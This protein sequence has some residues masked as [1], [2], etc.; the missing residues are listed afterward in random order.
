MDPGKRLKNALLTRWWI[1]VPFV[2]ALCVFVFIVWVTLKSMAYPHDG[3]GNISQSGVITRIEPAGPTYSK[4]ENEDKIISVDGIPWEEV[5]APYKDKHSGD[6]VDFLI[7]RSGKTILVPAALVDPPLSEILVRL[8]PILV[9]LVFWGLG[10][11]VQ[12]FK[13]KDGAANL[14]FAWCMVCAMTLAAGV[15]S[16]LEAIWTS[17][18]FSSLLWIIGP[19]SVHFHMDFPQVNS[20]RSKGFILTVLYSLAFL[21]ILSYSIM[22]FSNHH[23]DQWIPLL[24]SIG[25]IYLG[26]NLLFV[27]GLLMYQYTHAASP[28]VRAKI[29]LVALG[30]GLSGLSI[31]VFTI[32]PDGLFHQPILSYS[33]TFL[34]LAIIPLTYGYAIFRYHLIEIEDRVNRAATNFLIYAIIGGSYLV[35]YA[36]LSRA[37]PKEIATFP[38]LNAFILLLLISLF[39]PLRSWIQRFVD[40]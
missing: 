24:S 23:L 17:I 4:L 33:F 28:G 19:L 10:V 40:A 25:R 31:V 6:Q 26:A 29:R 15:A 32:L 13:P 39:T 38:L 20:W 2:I 21:G 27:V 5:H 30:G 12:T 9:A 11:G 1:Y 7:D 3:I 22:V 36:I 16:Y 34:L 37:L 8:V 18:L 14:F 35:F